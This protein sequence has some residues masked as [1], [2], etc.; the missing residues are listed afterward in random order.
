[1]DKVKVRYEVVENIPTLKKSD[2]IDGLLTNRDASVIRFYIEID[3]EAQSLQ[4]TDDVISNVISPTIFLNKEAYKAWDNRFEEERKKVSLSLAVIRERFLKGFDILDARF[5]HQQLTVEEK[6]EIGKIRNHVANINPHLHTTDTQAEIQYLEERSVRLKEIVGEDVTDEQFAELT[7]GYFAPEVLDDYT[8]GYHLREFEEL[9]QIDEQ[10]KALN[11]KYKALNNFKEPESSELEARL[12]NSMSDYREFMESVED[13]ESEL[14]ILSTRKVEIISDLRDEG[15]FEKELSEIDGY[16]VKKTATKEIVDIV[17]DKYRVCSACGTETDTH[18]CGNIDCKTITMPVA[19]YR[20]TKSLDQLD[21]FHVI[22]Y[23]LTDARVIDIPNYSLNPTSD[24]NK[25]ESITFAGRRFAREV[26]DYLDQNQVSLT[27]NYKNL[28]KPVDVIADFENGLSL[29]ETPKRAIYNDAENEIYGQTVHFWD[30]YFSLGKFYA[31]IQTSNEIKTKN[32]V[33]E[34][35]AQRN[36]IGSTRAMPSGK[37]LYENKV[38][39]VVSDAF[40]QI[41][42]ISEGILYTAEEGK[43]KLKVG[44]NSIDSI[45]A[46]EVPHFRP[47]IS[48]IMYVPQPSKQSQINDEVSSERIFNEIKDMVVDVAHQNEV[49]RYSRRFYYTLSAGYFIIEINGELYE[50]DE[51]GVKPMSSGTINKFGYITLNDALRY[52]DYSAAG[53]SWTTKLLQTYLKNAFSPNKGSELFFDEFEASA[54]KRFIKAVGEASK[55]SSLFDTI[56]PTNKFLPVWEKRESII[57]SS[58]EEEVHYNDNELAVFNIHSVTPFFLQELQLNDLIEEVSFQLLNSQDGDAVEFKR[59]PK[60]TETKKTKPKKAKK[61]YPVY[62]NDVRKGRLNTLIKP[63]AKYPSRISKFLPYTV[64]EGVNALQYKQLIQN[65][66]RDS[67]QEDYF[68]VSMR[69][70][71][72]EGIS[73]YEKTLI[74]KYLEENGIRTM[75]RKKEIRP[76][77]IKTNDLISIML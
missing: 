68:T 60:K 18:F 6:S 41:E 21:E 35:E 62:E 61:E 69:V 43:Y 51:N 16:Q 29:E 58:I 22:N 12:F 66:L 59:E 8:K 67:T 11:E 23:S 39:Y 76:I 74:Q 28:N 36:R 70:K 40:G 53:Q 9:A 72:R 77:P 26:K 31:I 10:I 32:L 73:L 71:L 47:N 57:T 49:Y 34:V 45:I 4:Q 37:D 42:K 5:K 56:L 46:L 52:K 15:H 14:E 33:D 20:F 65:G 44:L 63:E 55:P 1:M 2:V 24:T 48:G 13:Y 7:K 50:V 64:N 25:K 38:L 54:D 19:N 30:Y 75:H 27:L 3:K 17:N